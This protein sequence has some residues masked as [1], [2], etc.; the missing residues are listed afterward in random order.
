MT[1]QTTGSESREVERDEHLRELAERSVRARY[2][3]SSRHA[4]PSWL[5]DRDDGEDGLQMLGHGL[6]DV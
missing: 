5:T 3:R 2:G 6:D 4:L 1:D